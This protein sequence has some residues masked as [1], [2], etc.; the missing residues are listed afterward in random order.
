MKKW[1]T[2]ILVIG[3]VLFVGW[4]LFGTVKDSKEREPI[5]AMQATDFTLPSL[6]GKEMS[7]HGEQGKVVILNFWAS[8][9]EPCQYEMPHFQAFYEGNKKNVEILAVNITNKDEVAKVKQFVADYGLTFPVLLDESGEISTRFGAFAIPT[10]IILN[11]DGA[12]AHEIVGPLEE[13][14]LKELVDALL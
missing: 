11:Q 2:G 13:A 14:Q 3:V 12:I 4:E 5:R 9:C 10:T 1:L 7:L 6:E 8:W